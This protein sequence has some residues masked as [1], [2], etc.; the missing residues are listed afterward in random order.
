[1]TYPMKRILLALLLPF[2]VLL[3]SCDEDTIDNTMF[4]GTWASVA[5]A[6]ENALFLHVS[7]DYIDVDNGSRTYK[8]FTSDV[9]WNYII[10]SDSILHIWRSEYDASDEYTDTEA[11]DLDISFSNSYNTLTMHYKPTFGSVRKYT[12]IRR[13]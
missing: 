6:K 13:H 3:S 12:F 10:S 9:Q 1:M 8:P 7:E 5:N 11:Y 2:T 4:L